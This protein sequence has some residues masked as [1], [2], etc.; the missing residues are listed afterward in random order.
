M[1]K[2]KNAENHILQYN[3]YQIHC[4]LYQIFQTFHQCNTCTLLVFLSNWGEEVEQ[5]F[6][7]QMCISGLRNKQN[8]YLYIQQ[9]TTNQIPGITK[10]GI[11][12]VSPLLTYTA[13]FNELV[14]F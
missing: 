7:A 5:T 13:Q 6:N 9:I 14:T 11:I 4:S 12:M 2:Y 1:Y 8:H 3:P 10:Y